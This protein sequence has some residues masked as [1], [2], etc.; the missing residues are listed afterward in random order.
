ML[1]GDGNRGVYA[2]AKLMVTMQALRLARTAPGVGSFVADPGLGMQAVRRGSGARK[3]TVLPG[4]WLFRFVAPA[5]GL[6]PVTEE[7]SVLAQ[8]HASVSP[9]LHNMTGRCFCT[10]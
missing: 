1:W 9:H 3:W 8:L 6:V 5:V 2:D 10:T 7:E 4:A